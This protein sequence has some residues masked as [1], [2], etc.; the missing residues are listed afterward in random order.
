MFKKY[1]KN[2]CKS[3]S[4]NR[5]CYEINKNI[6]LLSVTGPT[7]PTGPAGETGP[8]GADGTNQVFAR[9]TTTVEPTEKANVVSVKEGATTY[10][11]FFIPKGEKGSAEKIEVGDITTLHAGEQ[12][13]VVDRFFDG[14][15]H[16]DFAIPC[17]NN[18]SKGENGDTGPMG[19]QGFPGEPG[20]VGP[21][22][23]KGD[24]GPQGPKGDKGDPGEKG[25]KG[26]PGDK[27]ETG[28]TG[29][30]GDTGDRG[31][32]GPT[33][34]DLILSALILSYNDDP[35]TFPMNGK[36]IASNSRLPLL[37]L[38]FN[39]D[40]LVTLDNVNNTIK[41]NKIGVYKVTF[42]VSAYVK[43]TDVDF[44]HSTD[45]VAVALR[46]V[47]SDNV[48]AGATTWSYNEVAQ[49]AY[50]QGIVS[51]DNVDNLYELINVQTKS[52][53][54]NGADITKTI[55]Q[56]YFSVPMISIIINKLS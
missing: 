22:G 33:G 38:E 11:D 34:P 16:F 8:T 27:G 17:G 2:K 30:K 36:E 42:C 37:R 46:Q 10:L 12:A 9:N 28:E 44:S 1:C 21:Q 3:H 54:I 43:K 24:T 25:E 18:G 13:T 53:Y 29:P 19:P 14:V 49:N 47:Q 31:P 26:E 4:N 6:R 52:I 32:I 39:R 56:S 51:V 40:E 23:P 48:I 5:V 35:N 50:G 45:F 20:I 7:G 41:F 55:S 15:H